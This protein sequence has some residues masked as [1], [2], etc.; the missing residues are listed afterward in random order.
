MKPVYI[1]NG[2][3]GSGREGRA[4][5]TGKICV[6]GSKLNENALEELLKK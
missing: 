5:V 4:D 3:L 1:I 6:I 2:F